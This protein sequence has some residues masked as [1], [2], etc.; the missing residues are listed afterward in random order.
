MW[1]L[2]CMYVY[3]K[4]QVGI[5]GINY[6]LVLDV[7]GHGGCIIG[8]YLMWSWWLYLNYRLVLDVVMVAVYF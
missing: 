7:G 5:V 4:L 8:W 6:R 2:M 1:Y 3:F